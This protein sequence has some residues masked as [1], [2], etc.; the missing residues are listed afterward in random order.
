MSVAQMAGDGERILLVGVI[1][2]KCTREDVDYSLGELEN[3]VNTLGGTVVGRLYQNRRKP[4]PATFIGSGKLD[5][6][7]GMIKEK[8]ADWIAFDHDLSAAQS[9]NI[10]SSL[11]IPVADRCSIILNIFSS[12]A[13]T[14]VAKMQ[15]ELANLEYL[16][17][18]LRHQWTHLSRQ[19]GGIGGRGVGEKQIELDRRGIE[20]RI[21]I[22]KKKLKKV[23]IQRKT[24]QKER[25]RIFSVALVGYTNSGKSTLLNTLTAATVEVEDKYF[26]TLDSK[27]ASFDDPRNPSIII[28]DTVGFIRKLPHQLVESFR[29]TLEDA[30]S[31][32]LILHVVDISDSRFENHIE[33][34]IEVLSELGLKNTP[35]LIVFN[36]VDQVDGKK[37]K[38]PETVTSLYKNSVAI[39]AKA[40]VGLDELKDAML[41]FFEK[42]MLEKTIDIDYQ[43]GDL[44]SRLYE[45][46]RVRYVEYLDDVVRV[47]LLA[48]KAEFARVEKILARGGE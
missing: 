17:P 37:I 28:S 20:T 32:D 40:E 3:L 26:S 14:A 19:Q 11:N 43:N 2:E 41:G 25:S 24:R 31:A 42:R 6:L 7:A 39:S 1:F 10:E 35:R 4:D 15:V 46:S 44:L 13:K 5:E 12:R 8:K 27:A 30:A 16:L 23:K 38:L 18:R 47:K 45:T 29:S 22:L 36:K 33:V 21:S 9:K 34:G 48:T